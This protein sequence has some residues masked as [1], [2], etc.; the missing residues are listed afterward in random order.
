MCIAVAIIIIVT[1]LRCVVLPRIH[2]AAPLSANSTWRRRELR[3]LLHVIID[4]AY[5]NVIY[6]LPEVEVGVVLIS[7]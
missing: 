5:F 6:A 4:I 3:T 7:C 2:T 1:L